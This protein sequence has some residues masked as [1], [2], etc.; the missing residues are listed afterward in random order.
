LP[1][2]QSECEHDQRQATITT[3]TGDYEWQYSFDQECTYHG[4]MTESKH[5]TNRRQFLLGRSA[6]Q[7]LEDALPAQSVASAPTDERK[8][9]AET[10]LVQV[11]R[12]AMACDFDIYLNAGQHAA[13]TEIAVSALDLVDELEAQMTVYRSDSEVLSINRRAGERAVVVEARLFEL[14][15]RAV[16]L[17]HMTG[18]AFDITSGPLSKAWGF[19][20]REGRFPSPEEVA[21]A[22]SRV[23]T[24]GIELD[25]DSRTVRFMRPD[26]EINLNAIGKGYAL[27]RCAE[28]LV[29]RGVENFLIHGGRSSILG[30]GSRALADS[31]GR[32]WLVAVKHPFRADETML[33]LWL[34]N[35]ALGTSGAGN[36]F[37]HFEGKRYGHIIDPRT[38]W[39]ADQVLSATVLAPDAATADALA[40]AF[41]VMGVDESIRYCDAHPKLAAIFVSSAARAGDVELVTHGLTPQ[42]IR[43]CDS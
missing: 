20:K 14:L 40:T 11:G 38:G 37:F 32:G 26:L 3:I 8:N 18:G 25:A 2:S 19:F 27:D 28:L 34:H 13:S 41:F 7:A 10:Y 35:R 16:E 24:E 6:F 9:A 22:K 4:V 21:T 15:V 30:R 42:E 12:S 5:P 1:R 31:Q 43:I 23:G 33:E 36:Q 17:Y 29:E 39:P